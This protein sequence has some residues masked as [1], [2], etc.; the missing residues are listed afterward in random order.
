MTNTKKQPFLNAIHGYDG[1]TVTFKVS[2]TF[3]MW[4]KTNQT[5]ICKGIDLL[6]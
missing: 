1:I 3:K 2:D 5:G 4:S 6:W